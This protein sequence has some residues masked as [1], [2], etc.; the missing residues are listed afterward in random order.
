METI[1]RNA[2]LAPGT[3]P[4][5]AIDQTI[6]VRDHRI[7]WMGHDDEARRPSDDTRVIDAGGATIVP[8]M[9]DAHSH[10][11]LPGGSHWIARG[12]DPAEGLLEV[13]EHNGDIA[14]R[15]GT[16]WF[17]DVG[18]PERDGKA[19]ALRVRDSW[20]G[21][22][23]R[24]YVRA[25]GTWVA[26][27]ETLPPGLSVEATDADQLVAAVEK[28]ATDGADLIKLYL[29]GPDKDV[30][31][32]TADEVARAVAAAAGHGLEV[33]AHA[34]VL[35]GARAAVEG[36]VHCIEHG[37]T[38]DTD[39]A[40]DMARRGTYLVPTLGV[41]ASWETFS[42]T[43]T[44]ERFAANEG[45]AALAERKERAFHS[46]APG[47]RGRGDDGRRHRLRRGVPAGQSHGLGGGM[48]GRGGTRTVEG[49]GRRHLGGWRA[50]GRGDGGADHRGRPGRFLPGTRQPPRG[51]SRPVACVAGGLSRR[52]LA[53]LRALERATKK[54]NDRIRP[55][56]ETYP[57][58]CD[59][60]GRCPW[61]DHFGSV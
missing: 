61:R 7:V 16:R 60:R 25:A 59:N 31:P 20:M 3:G 5:L 34:T 19:L 4:R 49:I 18:S 51:P 23:D 13:A 42:S 36:G 29:D 45:R 41:M 55:N 40:A 26:K 57:S 56:P 53:P 48:P 46:V 44:I 54:E 6:I 2:A 11:V 12:A 8:G 15:A 38:L 37:T 10:T 58:R 52:P 1:Y 28:Q 39:L 22:H 33:T 17:R 27:A 9:V 47:V 21:R 14:H 24:P 32:W 35:P 50:A 43:T 30:S